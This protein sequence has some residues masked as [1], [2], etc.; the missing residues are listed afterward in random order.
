MGNSTGNFKEYWECFERLPQTQVRGMRF[1][2]GSAQVLLWHQLGT[3]R[4][5][6]RWYSDCAAV[7]LPQGGFIWDWVD[8]GLLTEGKAQGDGRRVVGWGYGKI[9]R[10]LL[11]DLALLWSSACEE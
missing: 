5:P 11:H 6:D 1:R 8:Q 10:S 2:V 7:N 4:R 9:L 3:S